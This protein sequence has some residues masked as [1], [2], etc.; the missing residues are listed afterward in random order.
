VTAPATGLWYPDFSAGDDVA[1]DSVLGHVQ[2][3]AD[4]RRT[5]VLSPVTGRVFYGMHALTVSAGAELAA[6]AHP[7][8]A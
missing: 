1:A 2:D 7:S 6:L 5:P 3:P 8:G 4:G